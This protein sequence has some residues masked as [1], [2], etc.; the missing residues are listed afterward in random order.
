MLAGADEVQLTI[1]NHGPFYPGDTVKG[2]VRLSLPSSCSRGELLVRLSG[3]LDSQARGSLGVLVNEFHTQEIS[4][5]RVG[6]G[7]SAARTAQTLHSPLESGTHTFSFKFTLPSDDRSIPGSFDAQQSQLRYIVH[8][9]LRGVLSPADLDMSTTLRSQLMP[10]TITRRV[11]RQIC[12]KNRIE[13]DRPQLCRP[14]NHVGRF[15]RAGWLGKLKRATIGSA[16]RTRRARRGSIS[17]GHGV[18]VNDL[19]SCTG[20]AAGQS[21][22]DTA[23]LSDDG[24]MPQLKLS[25]P[26]TGYCSGE[27]VRMMVSMDDGETS[28]TGTSST[29]LPTVS[30]SSSTS[31]S[32]ANSIHGEDHQ[33]RA[34]VLVPARPRSHSTVDDALA[35]MRRESTDRIDSGSVRNTLRQ[36][37]AMARRSTLPA[38]PDGIAAAIASGSVVET[39]NTP[40]ASAWPL[41]L[42]TMGS[43]FSRM[44]RPNDQ[45]ALDISLRRQITYETAG[46]R[47]QERTTVATGQHL[48]SSPQGGAIE[49]RLPHKLFPSIETSTVGVTIDYRLKV[50]VRLTRKMTSTARW[51]L[52][53]ARTQTRVCVF[54]VPI[55]IGTCRRNE[56]TTELLPRYEDACAMPPA[57]ESLMPVACM[58][59]AGPNNSALLGNEASGAEANNTI[60][61]AWSTTSTTMPILP[62]ILT[63][64]ARLSTMLQPHAYAST[65][66][67]GSQSELNNIQ[68]QT[69]VSP[70]AATE[71]VSMQR[72]THRR[73]HALPQHRPEPI[74]Q[75][76]DGRPLPVDSPAT[77]NGWV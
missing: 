13:A 59:N 15:A 22:Q 52:G 73:L 34:S 44:V 36:T 58:V 16:V 20:D 38:I 64:Q 6:G 49:L 8:A 18:N 45:L 72:A 2:E 37:F 76:D 42:S 55:I 11:H 10:T 65:S 43:S 51:L 53:G 61:V 77:A 69:D 56:S 67:S 24:D 70:T 71:T 63:S 9:Q 31:S 33:Q 12:V 23:V 50:T 47:E 62:D 48:F 54:R 30:P 28:G 46:M 4:L 25:V 1:L 5:W 60:S 57:Y 14:V 66:D 19:R 41:N 27:W 39:A 35:P 74:H 29:T 7:Q 3:T 21:N 68:E 17:P 40:A 32:P 26:Q 75:A